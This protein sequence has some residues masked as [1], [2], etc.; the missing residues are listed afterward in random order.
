MKQVAMYNRDIEDVLS[1]MQRDL[2][3]AII[4]DMRHLELSLQEAQEEAQA[5]LQVVSV[6]DKKELLR[7][8]MRLSK[9]YKEIRSVFVTYA[10]AYDEEM[11]DIIMQTMRILI[12]ANNMQEAV[13]IGKGVDIYG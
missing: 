12:K 11:K 8:L 4:T 3:F 1:D 10:K 7:R 9:I 13:K 2:L 6:K 5:F